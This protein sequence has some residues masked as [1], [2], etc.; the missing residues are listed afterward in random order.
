MGHI[1]GAH[2]VKGEVKVRSSTDFVASRLC[3]PG[4]KH[5]KAPN[6]RYPREVELLAGRLQNQDIFL[7]Q[8]EVSMRPLPHPY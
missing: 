7:L 2:G 5:I 4:V 3:T 8:F 1:L 6:R